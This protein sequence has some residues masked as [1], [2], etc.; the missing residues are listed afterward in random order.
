[1]VVG[2]VGLFREP[3]AVRLL[4]RPHTYQSRPTLDAYTLMWLQRHQDAIDSLPA[5][6][7]YPALFVLADGGAS[8]SGYWAAAVM[9][10]LHTHTMYDEAMRNSYFSQ[11][12]FCLS[13]ASGGSVGNGSFVAQLA[14]ENTL[15][16]GARPHVAKRFL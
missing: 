1:M 4:A 7:H 12:L 10:Y 6:V 14:A 15:K 9:D 16:Q 13:G 8:R 11:Y 2:L 3:H 5:F